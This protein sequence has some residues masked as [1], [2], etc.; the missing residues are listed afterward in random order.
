MFP[1][2]QYV[3]VGNMDRRDEGDPML[4]LREMGWGVADGDPQVSGCIH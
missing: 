2:A 3:V 1:S 4:G